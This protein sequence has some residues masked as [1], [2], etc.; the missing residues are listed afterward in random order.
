MLESGVN[1]SQPS[2]AIDHH[3][4]A[5][6]QTRTNGENAHDIHRLLAHYVELSQMSGDPACAARCH[7]V[8]QQLRSF[9][10]TGLLPSKHAIPLS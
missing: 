6:V 8:E 9:R 10:Q 1:R 2:A 5:Q 7:D 3:L 4:I